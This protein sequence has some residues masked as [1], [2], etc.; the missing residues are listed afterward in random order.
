VES[1]SGFYIIRGFSY[2]NNS[3][4]VGVTLIHVVSKYDSAGQHKPRLQIAQVFHKSKPNLLSKQ[5]I[6]LRCHCIRSVGYKWEVNRRQQ[7]RGKS[8]MSDECDVGHNCTA[9]RLAQQS[10][11]GLPAYTTKMTAHVQGTF[12]ARSRYTWPRSTSRRQ[13]IS[14]RRYYKQVQLNPSYALSLTN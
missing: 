6:S 13:Q 1:Q 9:I 5:C 14:N 8:N 2:K 3:V 4:K 11:K 10:H 7:C 12:K